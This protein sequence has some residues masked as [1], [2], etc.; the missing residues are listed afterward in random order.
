MRIAFVSRRQLFSA[1]GFA[2][3]FAG[4]VSLVACTQSTPQPDLKGQDVHLTVIHTADL[5]SRFFPYEY[6]PNQID[7]NLGLV[8][9]QG[10]L[11]VVG[12]IGRVT[13]VVKGIRAASDR[14]IHLDSGDI[15]EGAPVFNTFA[16]EVEMRAMTRIGLG[17][18]CVGNHEFDKGATNLELMKTKFGGFPMLAANY[19]FSDPE[20][21]TQPKLRD[22]L[23]PYTII[24]AN[25]LT[26]GV[27]GFGNLSSLQ[28]IYLGGNSL[29]IRPLE[30]VQAINTWVQFVRP[31]VDLLILV[32]HL[33]LDVDETLAQQNNSTTCG[34]CMMDSDC[35]PNNMMCNDPTM[36]PSCDSTTHQCINCIVD[37]NALAAIQGVDVILGGHLH[38]VLDPPNQIPH[39]LQVI[40]GP[41][42]KACTATTDCTGD[43][44]GQCVNGTCS[45]C[46]RAGTG[47]STIVVDSGAF[48]KFIGQLDLNVHVAD[49]TAVLVDDNGMPILDPSGNQQPDYVARKPHVKS[50]TYNIIPIQDNIPSDPDMDNM[51]EPYDVNMHLRLNLGQQY[52]VIPCPVTASSCPKVQR[53]DASGGDSQLGNL[54]ATAMRLRKRVEADFGLTNSLGIRADFENGPINL[55]EMYNVFPFDNTITTIFL[56]GN[57]IHEMLDFLASRAAS[58]GCKSQAQVSGIY[59]VNDCTHGVSCGPFDVLGKAAGSC[60][61]T[62]DGTGDWARTDLPLCTAS[63]ADTDT[64]CRHD[65]PPLLGDNCLLLCD[66]AVVDA[67]HPCPCNYV[68]PFGSYRVAV[69]DYIA[70]GG[71]GFTVLQRNTSKFNTGISLRDA[72]NDF[73]RTL[74]AR[75][76][77]CKA[78]SDCEMGTCVGVTA[79]QPIGQCNPVKYPGLVDQAHTPPQFDYSNLPCITASDVGSLAHDGRISMV[80]P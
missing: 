12:G 65:N 36:C 66:P 23:S 22:V 42:C 30:T 9:T 79:Q 48:A 38:I 17:A 51:L 43:D 76:N 24:N 37:Q 19:E 27:I 40:E 67:A 41:G 46:K 68:T 53:I 50:F 28:G 62:T 45:A 1:Q 73:I 26:I 78:D 57:E 54:V 20:D 44:G 75:C 32:S 56:S 69:N 29:G 10:D 58:R 77:D 72:L 61:V 18:M 49:P 15:F 34:S 52:A 70:N 5:H 3:A 33:G 8:A 55:E 63:S 59:Y 31:Q 25:G 21:P 71:S 74:P 16:G 60:H 47:G 7:K 2:L 80:A 64:T 6:A 35:R 4:A 13:T 39:D 14:A 11:A